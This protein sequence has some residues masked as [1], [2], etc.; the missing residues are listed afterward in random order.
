MYH[1]LEFPNS[2]VREAFNRVFRNVPQRV[3]GK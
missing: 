3:C 2:L 1:V